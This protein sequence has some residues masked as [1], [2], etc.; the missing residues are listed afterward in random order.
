[1]SGYVG[2]A[3]GFGG[4]LA[5]GFGGGA[6]GGGYAG[7]YGYG[8]G[9]AGGYGFGGSIFG[10]PAIKTIPPKKAPIKYAPVSFP[11]SKPDD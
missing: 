1:M 10:G 3:P 5:P 4:S 9:Y 7:G 6:F 11:Y 2:G 8:G